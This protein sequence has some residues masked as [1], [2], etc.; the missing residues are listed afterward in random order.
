[1]SCILLIPLLLFAPVTDDKFIVLSEFQ[2]WADAA[3]P[4]VFEELNQLYLRR[5]RSHVFDLYPRYDYFVWDLDRM[6]GW[7]DEAKNLGAF[8]VFCIGDDTRTA[9]GHLFTT[10]GLNPQ[11]ADFFFGIVA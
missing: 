2:V 7:V 3:G 9:Q 11:L 5:G 8:N 6:K 10:A 1:M 4:H